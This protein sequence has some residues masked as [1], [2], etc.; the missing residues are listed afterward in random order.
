MSVQIE[1]LDDLKSLLKACKL[2][3]GDIEELK[4]LLAAINA[5][6]NPDAARVKVAKRLGIVVPCVAF[7]IAG[8]LSY[9]LTSGEN[10]NSSFLVAA[11]AVLWGVTGL[12]SMIATIFTGIIL[13]SR[14]HSGEQRATGPGSALGGPFAHAF[15]DRPLNSGR[16]D[17]AH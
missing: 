3:V 5:N 1:D 7:G 16:T 9:F 10:I 8:G 17:G 15:T 14:R 13:L 11:F 2:S 12:V 6:Y 4:S